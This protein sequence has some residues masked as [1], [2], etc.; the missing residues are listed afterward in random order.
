MK[1]IVIIISAIMSILLLSSCAYMEKG[2]SLNNEYQSQINI[3]YDSKNSGTSDNSGTIDTDN[4]SNIESKTEATE[5][6]CQIEPEVGIQYY[7]ENI[8]ANVLPVYSN[9][10]NKG[11]NGVEELFDT[12]TLY[13]LDDPDTIYGKKIEEI[14]D[15]LGKPS[16]DFT[17]DGGTFEKASNRIILGWFV[18]DK[19]DTILQIS[20]EGDVQFVND[21]KN[22]ILILKNEEP[23]FDGETRYATANEL[24]AIEEYHRSFVLQKFNMICYS[25]SQSRYIA[26]TI[27]ANYPYQNNPIS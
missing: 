17:T 21:L 5:T 14:L 16:L 8:E 4:K 27:D 24:K 22:G 11:I 9:F 6:S 12:E 18:N 26:L 13:P 20:F 7:F 19:K 15:I 3:S 25:E 2:G 10:T 23:L 1:I